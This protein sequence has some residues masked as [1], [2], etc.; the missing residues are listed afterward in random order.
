[1][2]HIAR[3]AYEHGDVACLQNVHKAVLKR[4]IIAHHQQEQS[5]SAIAASVSAIF[6]GDIANRHEGQSEA[7]GFEDTALSEQLPE[8]DEMWPE[9]KF[10]SNIP[11][12]KDSSVTYREE[13]FRVVACKEGEEQMFFKPPAMVRRMRAYKTL[14]P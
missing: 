3:Y 4:W 14:N 12:L 11:G 2:L 7:F 6:D 5:L 10:Q 13:C 1:M 9:I 8:S